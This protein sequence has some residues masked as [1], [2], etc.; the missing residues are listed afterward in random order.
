GVRPVWQPENN[1]VIGLEVIPLAELQ[2]PRIDVTVRMSGFFRDAFP[3]VVNLLDRA[4]NIIADLDE[5]E[6]QNCI[7]RHVRCDESEF[8]RKGIEHAAAKARYRLFSNKPGSYGTGMLNAITDS[9]WDSSAD[10]A[11]IYLE[12]G[13]YAYTADMHGEPAR[14]EFEL[15]LRAAD[16][17]VQNKDNYEHDIFDSDDYMQFH[18]GMIAAIRSLAGRDPVGIIGD[19]ANPESVRN[20]DLRDEARRVFR[21]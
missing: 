1:R 18:G 14:E 13:G 10:L 21:A 6:T 12:W 5:P 9:N 20:R 19:S 15:R 3:G 16:I 11:R 2:R 17:A 4:V 8:A 7:R